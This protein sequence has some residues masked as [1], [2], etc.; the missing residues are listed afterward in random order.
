MGEPN[1]TYTV[2]FEIVCKECGNLLDVYSGSYQGYLEIAPCKT[3]LEKVENETRDAMSAEIDETWTS[4]VEH[5]KQEA[6]KAWADNTAD[7]DRL[8]ELEYIL[9]RR[10]LQTVGLNDSTITYIEEDLTQDQFEK[11]NGFVNWMIENGESIGRATYQKVFKRYRKET[12]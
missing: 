5:G 12:S 9:L 11:L 2:E 4:G 10:A 8:S 7:E 3:C 6:T 1:L